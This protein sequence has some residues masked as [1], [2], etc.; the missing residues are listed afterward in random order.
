LFEKLLFKCVI[1]TAEHNFFLINLF[2]KRI[3]SALELEESEVNGTTSQEE[4]TQFAVPVF[5]ARPQLGD[6]N[7]KNWT[8]LTN[9][10]CNLLIY[11]FK[12]LTLSQ[13]LDLFFCVKT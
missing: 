13:R 2:V 8:Y 12:I 3:K 6:I 10:V 1:L 5:F 4:K 7:R 11:R 9:E